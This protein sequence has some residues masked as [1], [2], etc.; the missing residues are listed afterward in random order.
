DRYQ[1]AEEMD[2]DLESF[3]RGSS[4]STL[5]EES[6]TQ[7]MRAPAHP[8]ASTAATMISPAARRTTALPPPPPPVYYDLEEPIHRRPIWP[9]LAAA[10]FVLAAAVGGWFLYSTVS[11][12][13]NSTKPIGVPLYLNMPEQQARAKIKT[14]GFVPVVDHH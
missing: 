13:L 5:T 8:Y 3:L 12:K 4:V 7:I 9:W 14:D 1:S 6:A 2:A 10:I 11:D